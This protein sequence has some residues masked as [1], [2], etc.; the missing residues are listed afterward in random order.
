MSKLAAILALYAAGVATWW[1]V[2]GR[3]A[4]APGPAAVRVAGGDAG[5]EQLRLLMT[6][7]RRRLRAEIKDMVKDVDLRL[8]RIE[9]L[10]KSMDAGL[11]ATQEA[12][13]G[14]A[15]G[16]FSKLEEMTQELQ[17]VKAEVGG[18][19]AL[20]KPL[21]SLEGRVKAFEERIADLEA[22]PLQAQPPSEG[23]ARGT[24]PEPPSEP[25]R[26]KLPTEPQKDPDQVRREREQALRDIRSDD[27]DVLFPAIE[28][29]REHRVMDAV[30][31]LLEILQSYKDEFGRTAAAAALGRMEVCDAVPALAEALV[32]K[33][34]L[35]AQQAH[36]AIVQ[37]TRID[38]HLSPTARIRER[39]SVRN[40]VKEWWQSHEDEVRAR[41]GQPR[42]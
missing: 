17:A 29:I 4:T 1:L 39:R 16:S 21:A 5:A 7:A 15:E 3:G 32:D 14:A 26:P 36:K 34:S 41:L 40:K 18:L 9:S 11:A 25:E 27:L 20:A 2:D 30:P 22:R 10:R 28:K 42:K 19:K 6:E 24:K 12:A 31:R 33:S 37:I 38:S 23:S 35:V 13:E 8:S